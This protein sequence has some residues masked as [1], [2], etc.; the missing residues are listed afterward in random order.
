MRTVNT[1]YGITVDLSEEK[2]RDY[3]KDIVPYSSLARKLEKFAELD[4]VYIRAFLNER[5]HTDTA[6]TIR[7]LE[8]HGYSDPK[9]GFQYADLQD[10]EL[11]WRPVNEWL[12]V[13]EGQYDV[14]YVS[15]CNE[16]RIILRPRRSIVIYPLGVYAGAN[17]IREA[18]REDSAD[19]LEVLE[20]LVEPC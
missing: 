19:A 4:A 8:A 7:M 16:G 1:F 14:L 12:D 2:I 5:G 17:L 13:H 20:A 3:A 10:E 15:C 11:V 18:R 6:F 9:K